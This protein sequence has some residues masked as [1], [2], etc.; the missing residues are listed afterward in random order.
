MEV[1]VRER[2][3]GEGGEERAQEVVVVEDGGGGAG[4]VIRRRARVRVVST[5]LEGEQGA[6]PTSASSTTSIITLATNTAVTVASTAA[7]VAQAQHGRAVLPTGLS[8]ERFSRVVEVETAG[9]GH[10][11]GARRASLPH[12]ISPQ[13]Q[14]PASPHSR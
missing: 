8:G 14:L 9:G 4:S 5:T 13:P 6:A 11:E 10:S 12:H 7:Q 3:L 2:L 1:L